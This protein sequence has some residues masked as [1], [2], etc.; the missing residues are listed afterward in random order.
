MNPAWIIF[1]FHT[2]A[3]V[4]EFFKLIILVQEGAYKGKLYSASES[5]NVALNGK[6]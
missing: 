6:R 3:V 4:H 5:H 1:V 2:N